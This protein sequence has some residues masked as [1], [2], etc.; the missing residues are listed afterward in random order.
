[1]LPLKVSGAI[2]SD[3]YAKKLFVHVDAGNISPLQTRCEAHMYTNP[4]A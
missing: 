2:V 4:K 3:L 1:M